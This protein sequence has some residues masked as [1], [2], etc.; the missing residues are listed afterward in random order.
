[1]TTGL[2]AAPLLLAAIFGTWGALLWHHKHHWQRFTAW[3][4]AL[5]AWFATLAIP[6]WQYALAGLLQTSGGATVII[7]LA[8][9]AGVTFYLTAVRSARKSWLR[10]TLLRSSKKDGQPGKDLVPYIPAESPHRPDRHHRIWTPFWSIVAGSLGV[11]VFGGWR[12]LAADIGRSAASSARD[13]VRSQSQINSGRAAA[14]VPPSHRPG[15]YVVG[16]LV[17]VAIAVIMHKIDKHPQKKAE[18][19]ARGGR[20]GRGGAAMLGGG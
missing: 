20:G 14:A 6:A 12:L 7:V 1:M 3:M 19:A 15:I 5:T 11:V 2:V 9:V 8:M 10:R 18:K 17:L 4:F 16:I 13:L